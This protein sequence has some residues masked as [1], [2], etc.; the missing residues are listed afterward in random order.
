MADFRIFLSA[1][2][3]EF[4]KARDNLADALQSYDDLTVR[5]QRSFRHDPN[6]QS[7]LHQL[8]I[9]IK[10]CDA[11]VCLIGTR[12]GAGFPKPAEAAPFVSKGILPAALDRASYTQWEFLLA[13]H[14]RRRCLVYLASQNFTPEERE[15][16][17][18]DIPELQSTFVE[19]IL[20]VWTSR[21]FFGSP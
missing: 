4:G 8:A 9:Y 11:V 7:L 13:S 3:S 17:E 15:C 6:A 12:S 1:V 19:H 14:F 10:N 5:V 21:S 18:D 16:P 2:T 20:R